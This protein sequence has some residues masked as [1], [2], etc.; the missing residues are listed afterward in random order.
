M[1]QEHDGDPDQSKLRL[2]TCERL[3]VS[4]CSEVSKEGVMT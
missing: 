4:E 2:D 3:T 1:R